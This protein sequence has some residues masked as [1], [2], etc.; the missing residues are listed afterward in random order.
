M[1]RSLHDWLAIGHFYDE[2]HTP[3]ECRLRFDVSAQSWYKAVARRQMHLRPDDRAVLASRGPGNSQ[4]D[5]AAVQRY[6]DAG[7]S[8]R[9]CRAEFGF[10]AASWTNAVNRGVLIA[11]ARARP[12][13][14]ALQ[15]SKCRTSLK[16][17]LLQAGML[18]NRCDECGLCEW[19]GKP[20]SIQIDHVNGIRD[21]NRIENLR[22]L[23]P[24]C[25]SQT[26]TFSGRNSRKRNLIPIGVTGN[27]LDSDSSI[28]GSNP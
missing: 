16:L 11:R 2:G 20:L 1:P 28:R 25:H 12:I 27:T 21:D 4:Y 13:L 26:E 6:Y 18:R 22:M 24:N 19:R 17:R 23:C 10:C 5:W 7:H 9:A 14:L 8:Y 3:V 15:E